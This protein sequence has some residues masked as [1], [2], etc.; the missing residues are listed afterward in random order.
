MIT[1]K[2]HITLWYEI[3]DDSVPYE[4]FIDNVMDA[5]DSIVHW[6]GTPASRPY[7]TATTYTALLAM[8][9]QT[10]MSKLI[11]ENGGVIYE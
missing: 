2:Y 7:F 3:E 10:E 11:V 5:D 1:Q 9:L 8:Q 6:A 4:E